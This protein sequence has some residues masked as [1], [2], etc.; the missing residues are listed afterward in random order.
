[1]TNHHL[2]QVMNVMYECTWGQSLYI[3]FDGGVWQG[4]DG[5]DDFT[6]SA[7]EG[8]CEE[9]DSRWLADEGDWMDDEDETA[10]WMRGSGRLSQNPRD[11]GYDGDVG[12]DGNELIGYDVDKS[13][14]IL[15]VMAKANLWLPHRFRCKSS[16]W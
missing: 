1:M 2:T 11:T 14:L 15:L 13:V 10:G 8:M 6:T 3:S 4:S 12:D 5:K 9:D 7:K 16:V